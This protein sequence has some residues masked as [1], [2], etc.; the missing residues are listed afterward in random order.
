MTETGSTGGGFTETV[1]GSETYTLTETGN[2]ATQTFTRSI[3]G[4]GTYT[5]SDTGPGATITS[6]PARTVIRRRRPAMSP[7]RC[8]A[9]R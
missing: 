9:K 5:W 7:A 1:N 4:S 3:T 6:L 8:S 2:S